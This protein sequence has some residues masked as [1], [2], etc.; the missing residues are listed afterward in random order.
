ME[1]VKI[2]LILVIESESRENQTHEL[3]QIIIT[4]GPHT[5][6][7]YVTYGAESLAFTLIAFAEKFKITQRKIERRT[8]DLRER[9]G[10]TDI[11]Y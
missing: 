9:P 10:V 6:L 5:A 11:V 4:S 7:R 8:E 1:F 2:A 3:K